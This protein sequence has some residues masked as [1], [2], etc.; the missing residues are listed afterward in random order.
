MNI[1]PVDF[2]PL[3]C[4]VVWDCGVFNTDYD[5][6]DYLNHLYFSKD[7]PIPRRLCFVGAALKIMLKTCKNY[8]LFKPKGREK[9]VEDSD[10]QVNKQGWQSFCGGIVENLLRSV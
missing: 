2:E 3:W 1:M 4:L 7:K 6:Q 5:K 8:Y 10:L 9:R